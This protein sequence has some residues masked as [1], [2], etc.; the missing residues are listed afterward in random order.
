MCIKQGAENIAI[1]NAYDTKLQLLGSTNY[2]DIEVNGVVYGSQAE[3][4]AALSLLLFAKQ[5]NYIVQDINATKLTS[6]GEITVDSNY[7]TIEPATWVINGVDF[8]TTTD[9]VLTIPYAASGK[10][11][12][13]IIVANSS[14]QIVRISG[15]E[16]MGLALAPI[17]PI[18]SV[19]ISQI[20]VNDNSIDTPTIPIIG[21]LFVQKDE[22]Y[23]TTIDETG[24]IN[25][26]L[27]D[28]S[29]AFRLTNSVTHITGL[30]GDTNF[31]NS[32]FYI[33][34]ELKIANSQ[35]TSVTL[36][37]NQAGVE[38]PMVFPNEDDLILQPNEVAL[39]KFIKTTGTLAEL[40]SIN[41][42][43]STGSTSSI[44]TN[45]FLTGG[46]YSI[47]GGTLYLNSN[48]GTTINISGFPKTKTF[49]VSFDGGG[50]A[51]LSGTK[52]DLTI[53]Y[54]MKIESWTLLADTIGSIVIDVW[55][56]NYSN[57]PPT[58]GD[59]ITGSEKPTI[60]AST[61]NQ[62]LS[63]STWNTIINAG[64]VIRFNVDSCSTITKANL[65]IKGYE[66]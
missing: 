2:S 49:G 33:G 44:D 18:D 65:V 37:H 60:S 41:R 7:V 57:F 38:I 54:S 15:S 5:F 29:T 58:S 39:F 9:T 20:T 34:K 6:I 27:T 12:I 63:L 1:H 66:I 51:I 16:T 10:T 61:K 59:T 40:T 11:R 4:M 52:C 19:Y 23:E 35:P 26:H 14:N 55:K 45:T 32:S 17:T 31:F 42:I 28:N 43:P 64:D 3:L 30:V 36:L 22:F 48:S 53:P 8:E 50:S 25:L 47:S 62:D 56:D 13:D 21:T 24:S 46:T